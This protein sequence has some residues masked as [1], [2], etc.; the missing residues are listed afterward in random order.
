MH[1]APARARKRIV[2][3]GEGTPVRASLSRGTLRVLESC[4][5]MALIL[6]R[7]VASYR[8]L[9]GGCP[10]GYGA[11]AGHRCGCRVSVAI[12]EAGG[13]FTST[14]G[15]LWSGML[16]R[17]T[18]GE[19][20]WFRVGAARRSGMLH[21]AS[22]RRPPGTES[23]GR[24]RRG[25]V[26]RCHADRAQAGPF[27]SASADSR[28]CSRRA[29]LPGVLL[30]RSLA[31]KFLPRA[32]SPLPSSTACRSPSR[33]LSP[34]IASKG[35]FV[36]LPASFRRPVLDARRCTLPTIFPRLRSMEEP[37][38]KEIVLEAHAAG[39]LVPCRDGD[40]TP[41]EHRDGR[42]DALRT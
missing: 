11:G 6:P 36:L 38:G 27:H 25:L 30:P 32:V 20:S 22:S 3:T 17:W 4:A 21:P 34:G 35:L 24:R 7:L 40:T 15:V 14:R 28:R 8:C 2:R 37:P 13:C 19:A 23:S 39:E 10:P 41:P 16:E 26:F 5:G 33:P 9:A 12:V 1:A 31:L 18:A 29:P 42:E